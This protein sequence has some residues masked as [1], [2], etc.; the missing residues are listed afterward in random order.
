MA[1][2]TTLTLE[3]FERMQPPDDGRCELDEGDLLF[4]TFPNPRH[5]HIVGTIYLLLRSFVEPRE[6]GWVSPSDT[7]YIVSRELNTVLGPDV[8]FLRKARL[9]DADFDHNIAGPPDLAVEVVSEN[10]TAPRLR[11]KV[12][13]YLVAGAQTVWVVYPEEREVHVFEASGAT[14]VLGSKDSLTCPN[15]LTDFSVIVGRLFE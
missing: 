4:M 9:S 10:D 1:A 13:Q 11:R 15:L 7:G 6:L 8:S 2:K 5:N 14:L 12:R 3:Q